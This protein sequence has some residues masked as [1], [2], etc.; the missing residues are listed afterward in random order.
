MGISKIV[1]VAVTVFIVI[2]VIKILRTAY[3]CSK[4]REFITGVKWTK[5]NCLHCGRPFEQSFYYCCEAQKFNHMN[6]NCGGYCLVCRKKY[7]K[8]VEEEMRKHRG[9]KIKCTPCSGIGKIKGHKCVECRG[10]GKVL[11]SENIIEK[12]AKK[13]VENHN[14]EWKARVGYD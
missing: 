2:I 12:E 9:K 8:L 10:M 11:I 4:I 5:A 7:S 1:V 13:V 14:P 3:F 6:N